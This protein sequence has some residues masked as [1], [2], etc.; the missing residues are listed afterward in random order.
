MG[1]CFVAMA[2]PAVPS[3]IGHTRRAYLQ[4]LDIQ[5]AMAVVATFDR[6][7]VIM[8]ARGMRPPLPTPAIT[9]AHV[10]L[11][12]FGGA[13]NIRACLRMDGLRWFDD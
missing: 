12:Q 13:A 6:A 5:E 10:F 7:R 4:S 3:F 11:V 2:G 1:V 8:T 9:A